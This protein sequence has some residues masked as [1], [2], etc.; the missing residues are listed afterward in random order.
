MPRVWIFALLT[1][2]AIS[3]GVCAAQGGGR[4]FYVDCSRAAAG[5]GS[6]DA[7][8]NRLD[9]VNVAAFGPG[10]SIHLRR[11]TVC[12]GALAPRGSGSEGQAI[13]LTAYGEGA[14]PRVV[15]G[16]LVEEAM[17][18]FNQQ[19]WEIDSLDLSGGHTYGIFISG[20]KGVLHH[21]HLAN[22]AI[23]D[24]VGGEMKH[25]ESGLVAISPSSANTHFDDVVV[26]GVNAWNTNQWVGILV[27]GGN[28]GFPPESD[29][30][31]NVV[32]RNSTVHD[33]QGDGIVL[34]RV[35]KGV[36]DSSVAW[37]T[38]MQDTE[39]I[40]TPNAIWT[41]MCDE[42]TVKDS[43]AYLTDSPGVDGGAFDIDYGNTNN[44]VIDNYGHDTQGYCIA[45]FG[46]GFVT[47]GSVVRGNLCIDNGRSPRMAEYQGALF[48]WTWNGGSI[49]GLTM[50]NNTVY[51]NPFENS[52]ALLN[53]AEIKAGTAR[54]TGNR[55][56][57]TAPWMV[58]SNAAL[59]L[60]GNEY[61]YYGAGQPKWMYGMKRFNDLRQM[62]QGT[63]EESGG[64]FAQRPVDDWFRDVERTGAASIGASP[65]KE[66]ASE[67]RLDCVLP[68]ALD[69]AGL[70]DD[71]AL[72][73]IVV[74]KSLGQQYRARG[75]RVTLRFTSSDAQLFGSEAFENALTDLDLEDIATSHSSRTGEQQLTLSM[76]GGKIAERWDGPVGP[77]AL[78][79][80]LRKAMGE[81]VYAQME[82]GSDE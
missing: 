12:H 22:L 39:S 57:S 65:S 19:Y 52:P 74:L 30:N 49:D 24:V 13:R 18:L 79:F 62:Q 80:A 46:A 60:Q 77:V 16:S 15:A 38:G 20:D 55:I 1:L 42:C 3:A 73:Q 33:V 37:N 41:W 75:L 68:I 23:H 32:I 6:L 58:E 64:H 27:G 44:S 48:L 29:W 4:S 26:D 31:S 63:D 35:R 14:R 81:P 53:R 10:D 34:F 66:Q 67:W 70:V 25:K 9:E 11:G 7:P 36:I 17:R 78:G 40:G 71:E 21:I 47:R 8:W 59:L 28:L 45:V 54:F 82:G 72:K 50:E 56:Y 69:K 76:P 51:W 61:T 2:L 5:S 43:E